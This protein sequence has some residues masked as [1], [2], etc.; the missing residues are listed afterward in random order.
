MK[1][2]VL[3]WTMSKVPYVDMILTWRIK[4]MSFFD[5]ERD[6]I[7]NSELKEEFD[8][9]GLGN[10]VKLFLEN[11]KSVSGKISGIYESYILI[12]GYPENIYYTQIKN[13]S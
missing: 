6:D 11:G 7:I 2:V 10:N 9:I 1:S 4:N 13:P 5:D 12:D 3:D 8:E